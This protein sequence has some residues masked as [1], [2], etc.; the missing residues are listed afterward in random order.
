M[1]FIISHWEKS[2]SARCGVIKTH[3]GEIQTPVFMPIGTQG[4]VKTIDP[5]VLSHLHTQII[6]GNTYHL[7]LRPGHE[8]IHKAGSLHAFMNWKKSILT[9]SGGFQVFSLAQLNKI[10]DEGVAFQSHLDGSRHFFTPE[11]SME[12]QRHL[13]ADIIMAFDECPA[14]KSD[15][16]SVEKAVERTTLWIDQCHNYLNNQAPLYDW[17]QTLFPIV[18]GS[19]YKRMRKRSV[20]A[21]IPYADC[22]I[23]IGGLAV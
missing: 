1:Q 8:L 21:L 2:N 11:L 22:G 14:A 7:Y 16:A 9:D 15:Q 13:G 12:I 17:E 20:E 18:Q 6:L 4:A 23:A 5:E 19:I 3:H 10:S